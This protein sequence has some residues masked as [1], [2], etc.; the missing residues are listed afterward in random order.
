MCTLG[1]FVI[2]ALSFNLSQIGHG[3]GGDRTCTPTSQ[4]ILSI[5]HVFGCFQE[6]PTSLAETSGLGCFPFRR[7][8]AYNVAAP[9]VSPD[10]TSSLLIIVAR[11]TVIVIYSMK[12]FPRLGAKGISHREIQRVRYG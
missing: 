2:E 10:Y 8:Q 7:P 5:I 4:K 9:K 3:A 12:T 11:L 1:M 6:S